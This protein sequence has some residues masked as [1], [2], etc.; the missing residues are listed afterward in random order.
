MTSIRDVDTLPIDDS[1]YLVPPSPIKAWYETEDVSGIFIPLV[2]LIV[3]IVFFGII[4]YLLLSS[5]FE[6][7][8][9]ANRVASD[10]RSVNEVFTCPAGQ[11]ATDLFTGLKT[12]PSENVPIIINP[13]TSVCNSRYVCDN[14]LTPFAIM[15]DGSTNLNGVCEPGVEC[16]CLRYQQCPNY[17]LSAFTVRGGNVYQPIANQRISFPQISTYLSEA[18]G[19]TTTLPPIQY[20]DSTTFCF[21][22]LAWLPLST[23]GCNFYPATQTNSMTIEDVALCQGMINGCTGVVGNPC[24]QGVLAIISND[25]DN[26]NRNNIS[27]MQFGCVRGEP[28]PCGKLAVYDT[29]FGGIICRD[30]D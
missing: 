16:G 29:N 10:P 20:N 11:C 21:A 2:V 17:I 25:P 22:S 5:N 13:M 19:E 15:S 4:G 27:T 8:N 9:P 28:C 26:I 24:L 30:I 23:P 18:T 14:T 6:S 12:C 7:T 3:F 1:N